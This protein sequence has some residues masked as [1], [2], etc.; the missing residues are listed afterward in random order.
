M[1]ITLA[2]LA[3]QA[4]LKKIWAWCKKYWQIL[5]GAAIPIILMLIF[6]KRGD[7]S[8]ILDRINDDYKKE[9]D[10]IENQ[11]ATEIEKRENAQKLYLETIKRLEAEYENASE[12][13]DSNKKKKI[14]ELVEKYQ[15]D[16]DGLADKIAELTGI[17]R[18]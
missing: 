9:I 5:L 4:W 7:L 14:K 11:H 3:V 12:T 6:Q 10:V 15:D 16:P 8:K 13:L 18:V 2:W 1:Q 17:K